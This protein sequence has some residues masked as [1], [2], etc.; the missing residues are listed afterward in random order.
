MDNIF[1]EFALDQSS[2]LE[3]SLQLITTPTQNKGAIPSSN[4]KPSMGKSSHYAQQSSHHSLHNSQHSSNKKIIDSLVLT[5]AEIVQLDIF[6]KTMEKSLKT[7]QFIQS[8]EASTNN[9]NNSSAVLPRSKRLASDE[10]RRCYA[11]VPDFFFRSDFA[12]TNQEIFNKVYQLSTSSAPSSSTNGHS[13]Y[14]HDLSLSYFLD[15]I[16]IA[17]L[18]QI[19]ARSPAFFRALD[20]LK[21]LQFSVSEAT[22]ST[23]LV[24]SS[25]KES[26]EKLTYHAMRIPALHKRQGNSS[27]LQDKLLYMQQV[28]SGRLAI[29]SLI[30]G[31]DYF[32]A[33]ELTFA[34]KNI[35]HKHLQGINCFKSLGDQLDGIDNAICEIMCNKFVSAAM[36]YD[37]QSISGVSSAQSIS[38]L[39][40][41]VPEQQ[42]NIQKLIQSLVVLERLQ[43][44]LN[45]YKQ[46]LCD[47][48]KLIVRTCAMEFIAHFDPLMVTFEDF[49]EPSSSSESSSSQSF[50][51]KIK[52]MSDEHFIA[53]LSMCYEHVLLSLNKA[54][55]FHEFLSSL[56]KKENE[57]ELDGVNSGENQAG[58]L[59]SDNLLPISPSRGCI[60]PNQTSA[61][62]EGE[63][64]RLSIL[65][66]S[67]I[68]AASELAQRNISQLIN[69]RREQ[70]ASF[71]AI[72][73]KALW[74]NSLSFVLSLESC[75]NSTAYLLRQCLVTQSKLFLEHFSE[76]L[77]NRLVNALDNERW[78]QCDVSSE[79]QG[80]LDRLS[81]GKAFLPSSVIS[82]SPNNTEGIFFPLLSGNRANITPAK[83]RDKDFQAAVVDGKEFKVV[84]SVLLLLEILL[85]YLDISI[86]FS[87]ITVDIISKI[88]EQIRLFNSRTKQLVLG[89]QAIQSAARLKSISAKHLALTGQSLRIM[90]CLLP[91]I[92]TALLAQLPLKHQILL[93]EL[94]RVSQELLDHHGLVVGKFVSIVGDFIEASASKLTQIDWDRTL[95]PFEY[96]EEIQKNILALHRVLLSILPPE[97]ITDIFS[98]IFA[99]INRKIPAHFDDIMPSTTVGKQRIL[100]EITHLVS[101]LARLKLMDST[102]LALNSS[103]EDCFRKK[104]A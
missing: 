99:L 77:K 6:L 61:L 2:P 59:S 87:P 25:L 14:R 80:Q 101:A 34:L 11:E 12:L 100:D 58:D 19:W 55:L 91:H 42:Q 13:S 23:I 35:Y 18:R 84:W 5:N 86:N 31:E 103:L 46:R 62:D 104:Y 56:L 49:E 93:T 21:S 47:A 37:D 78:S 8:N 82:L 43:S 36:Q 4:S 32:T 81:S 29:T 75:S 7:F 95:G 53:C 40:V 96:F 20:D 69:L 3:Y 16:E 92:R 1:D 74:E 48:I 15:L 39:N 63:L 83:S 52:E 88:V 70:N 30:E 57:R 45:M 9:H 50:V 64:S 102:A 24:R 85:T 66:K 22:R 44:A 10:L 41:L 94:D 67:I 76:T 51:H 79:R 98:R 89:A 33:Q 65:S 72:K 38:A 27:K 28:L 73:M 60:S 54:L 97:Q 68:T 71:S 17:L 90:I 26:N